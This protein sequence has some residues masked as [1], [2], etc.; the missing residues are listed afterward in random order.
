MRDEENA[1]AKQLTRDRKFAPGDGRPFQD[2]ARH[3]TP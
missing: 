2:H 3:I 1:G